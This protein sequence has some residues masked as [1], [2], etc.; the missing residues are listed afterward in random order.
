MEN[1][2][3]AEYRKKVVIFLL[4]ITIASA[5]AAAVVFPVLKGLGLYPSVSLP[6]LSHSLPL[7]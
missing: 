5:S 6:F 1:Q 7:C 3:L 4:S 2:V